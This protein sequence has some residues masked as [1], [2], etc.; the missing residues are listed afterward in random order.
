MRPCLGVV[1]LS[2]AMNPAMFAMSSHGGSHGSHSSRVRST[3]THT[4]KSFRTTTHTHSYYKRNHAAAGFTL[5]PTVQ[6][7]SNGRIKRSATA[8]NAFK[9]EHPCPATGRSTGRCPGYV[10]D[11][12][13]ALECGGVDSPSNMQWQTV[14]AGKAKDKTE[15]H[16]R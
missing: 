6:R 1:L 15:R 13:R 11:H 8:K 12:V 3:R 14:T 9:R 7:D 2:I 4:S 16:C 5:H 10:V